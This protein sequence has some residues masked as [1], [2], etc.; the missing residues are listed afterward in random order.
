MDITLGALKRKLIYIKEREID[1][2]LKDI[3]NIKQLLF[4]KKIDK[5]SVSDEQKC[6]DLN[7][8]LTNDRSQY[9][10]NNSIINLGENKGTQI[11]G[12]NNMVVQN[13]KNYTKLVIIIAV[14]FIIIFGIIF[15]YP[16]VKDVIEKFLPLLSF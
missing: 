15:E 11:A 1:E 13:E 7:P 4:K 12:K 2:G 8:N 14:T 6:D 10:I 9:K 16:Y 5:Y 3:K